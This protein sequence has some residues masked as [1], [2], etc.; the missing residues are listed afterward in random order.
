MRFA[1]ISDL[2]S[3]AV[4]LDAVLEDI[5]GRGVDE[6]LCLGDIVDLGPQPQEVVDRLRALEIRCIEGNHDPL[7]EGPDL[8]LLAAIEPCSLL[9]SRCRSLS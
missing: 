9:P 6:V 7:D 3:H 2:H 4:A 5:S 1:L 8:P